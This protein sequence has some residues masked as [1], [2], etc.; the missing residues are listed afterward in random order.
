MIE[1]EDVTLP[2]D[3]LVSRGAGFSNPRTSTGLDKE[4]LEEL[5]ENLDK[6][7]LIHPLV[8]W[9]DEA[10]G[11]YV[12]ID[13]QRRL[14]AIGL[15]LERVPGHRYADGVACRLIRAATLA[16]AR[17][18]ALRTAL[19]RSDLSTYEVAAALS[20][21]EGTVTEVAAAIGRSTGYTSLLLTAW[22]APD[23][24]KER[25]RR[26]KIDHRQAYA[27]ARG[28]APP[29][30]LLDETVPDRA[31]RPSLRKIREELRRL[32][33]ELDKANG[34][35]RQMLKGRISALEWVAYGKTMEE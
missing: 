12:V 16:E 21:M 28:V 24:V 31:E 1:Y 27:A 7:G 13:G 11:C 34:T 23:E 3:L 6:G 20:Q 19:H 26:G 15:I 25:W 32:Y 10:E 18:V 33:T 9:L 8:V 22:G 29:E 14:L 2:P 17:A 4:S 35:R 30:N 5:A